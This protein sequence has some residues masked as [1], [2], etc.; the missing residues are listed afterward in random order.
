M[1]I[2]DKVKIV[3]TALVLF[4]VTLYSIAGFIILKACFRKCW[5]V[6]IEDRTFRRGS[7]YF[8]S[9]WLVLQNLM[10][11]SVNGFF[12]EDVTHIQV[13]LLAIDVGS[14]VCVC[15]FWRTAKSYIS[16][17]LLLLYLILKTGFDIVIYQPEVNEWIETSLIA[18]II[19]IIL[20]SVFWNIS[21]VYRDSC[22]FF[23]S[24]S[25]INIPKAPPRSQKVDSGLEQSNIFKE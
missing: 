11:G 25:S 6:F 23:K 24:P 21:V 17:L 1:E 12:Q 22:Q 8:S 7:M 5:S 3:A 9:I 2:G 10:T 14:I 20:Y 16:N 13:L 15:Y 19:L 18:T 4:V